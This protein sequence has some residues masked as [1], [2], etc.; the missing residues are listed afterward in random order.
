MQFMHKYGVYLVA[1]VALAL[2]YP[3]ISYDYNLDDEL[4]TRGSELEERGLEVSHYTAY[5]TDSL[6]KIFSEPYYKDSKG[7]S[8]G[9][10]PI[11]H[12]SFALEHAIFGENA[13]TS[14]TINALL[15]ALLSMM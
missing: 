13:A 5:G 15:Y 4:V 7:N 14:H 2:Y 1:T 10:R 6:S 9:F 12:T 3:T 11:T 8:Y